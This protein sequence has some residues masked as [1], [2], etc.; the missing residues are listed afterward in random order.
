MGPL[1]VA[2]RPDI[3]IDALETFDLSHVTFP[4]HAGTLAFR[5]RSDP[6]FAERASSVF[7]MAGTVVVALFTALFAAVRFLRGLRKGRI[8]RFYSAAIAIR[9]KLAQE[10]SAAQRAAYRAELRALRDDAFS[11]LINEK[12]AADESFK[13]LQTLIHDVIRECETPPSDTQA[14]ADAFR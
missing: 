4:V 8:D 11:L 14:L 13:I 2:Q 10:P 5:A 3:E 9:T 12:L 6:G 7:Q 1:L